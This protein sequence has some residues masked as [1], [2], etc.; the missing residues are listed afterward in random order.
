M[1]KKMYRKLLSF[2][3]P[4]L[5]LTACAAPTPAGPKISVESAWARPAIMGSM[6]STPEMQGM[7]GMSGNDTGSAGLFCDRE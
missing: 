3:V 7:P 1:M 4:L 2:L 6:S 5:M